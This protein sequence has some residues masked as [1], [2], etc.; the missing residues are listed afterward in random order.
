MPCLR[1]W[2]VLPLLFW[3]TVSLT[4]APAQASAAA[5]TDSWVYLDPAQIDSTRFLGP[6]P[7]ADATR[8]EIAAMLLLQEQRTPEQ[9]MQAAA[10]HE[11]SVFRFACVMGHAFLRDHLPLTT[12]LFATLHETGNALEKQGKKKWRRVRP[13]V[14][15]TRIR[16]VARYSASGSYPSGH[17]TFSFL[18]AIVL[19][20]MVPEKSE[21]IFTRAREFG[22]HR[23][24]GGVH[25]PS[26]VAAGQR[27]ATLIAVLI[28]QNPAFR[29]DYA[30]ARTELRSALG[31]P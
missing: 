6:P 15:D 16:P 25:Y 4:Q 19:A 27:L 24:I 14:F 12:R 10:D 26:D 22:E 1:K 30:A 8:R 3:C 13:P 17:A 31:L 2:S 20:D 28:Q 11:Q 23:V 18:A 9:V 5:D 21:Q 29:Q 7:D